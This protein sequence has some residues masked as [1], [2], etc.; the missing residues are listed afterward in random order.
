MKAHHNINKDKIWRQKT[1]SLGWL[2]L[3]MSTQKVGIVVEMERVSLS[4]SGIDLWEN[5]YSGL[6]HF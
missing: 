1:E 3:L 6:S 4:L 5:K 2:P